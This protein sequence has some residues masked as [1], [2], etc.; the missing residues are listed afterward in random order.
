MGEKVK[1]SPERNSGDTKDK[2]QKLRKL[3][4]DNSRILPDSFQKPVLDKLKQSEQILAWKETIDGVIDYLDI[5]FDIIENLDEVKKVLNY[6]KDA[7]IWL[8]DSKYGDKITTIAS[9]LIKHIDDIIDLTKELEK[10]GINSESS[11]SIKKSIKEKLTLVIG[12][13]EKVSTALDFMKFLSEADVSLETLQ[14][15]KKMID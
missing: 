4:E 14:K 8:R 1:K 2:L 9:D 15:L 5:D 13:L 12:T 11:E 6:V 7:A 3:V 10:V